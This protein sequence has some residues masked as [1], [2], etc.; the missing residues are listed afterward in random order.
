MEIIPE[1]VLFVQQTLHKEAL[2]GQAAS[3]YVNG[4]ITAKCEASIVLRDLYAA[5]AKT[6]KN[7]YYILDA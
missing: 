2:N 4:R 1:W 3:K 5:V 6:Y 7:G